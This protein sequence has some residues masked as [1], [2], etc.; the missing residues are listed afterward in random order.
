MA[1]YRYLGSERTAIALPPEREGQP[2]GEVEL[3]PDG[4]VELPADMPYVQRLFH[5]GLL[6]AIEPPAE[7]QPEQAIAPRKSK[8]DS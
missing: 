7:P 5:K 8:G 4:E 3:I 6:V 1:K 2:C